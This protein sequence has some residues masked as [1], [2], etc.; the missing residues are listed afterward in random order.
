VNR[1]VALDVLTVV[2]CSSVGTVE[3][4][5]DPIAPDA[6]DDIGGGATAPLATVEP[7]IAGGA[8]AVATTLS[9]PPR[10]VEMEAFRGVGNNIGVTATTRAVRSNAIES[11]LSIYGTGSKP[12][13]R[14][15]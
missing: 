6:A 12:P 7:L 3:S 10:P 9:C 1:Y 14:K 5:D 8:V 13:G 11:L 2:T 15:G 4:A